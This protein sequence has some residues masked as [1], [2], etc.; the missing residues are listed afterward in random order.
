[1][2]E[3]DNTYCNSV[4]ENMGRKVVFSRFVLPGS[5]GFGCHVIATNDLSFLTKPLEKIIQNES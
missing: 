3:R 4:Q 2:G 1:M 5:F